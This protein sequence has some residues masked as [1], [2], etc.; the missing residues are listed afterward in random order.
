M[1]GPEILVP[2][3]AFLSISAIIILRGPLG[4]AMADR[5]AGRHQS[6]PELE[7]LREEVLELRDRL[8]EAEERIDFNE[9]LL[10]RGTTDNVSR[11]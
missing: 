5:L 10:S 1:N 9:R 2:I 3:T 11:T 7:E 8:A 4:R 6:S